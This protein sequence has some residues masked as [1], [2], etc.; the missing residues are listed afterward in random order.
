MLVRW[1]TVRSQPTPA[2]HRSGEE[3]AL[4]SV[5]AVALWRAAGEADAP[6][7][8]VPAEAVLAQLEPG[9]FWE[10]ALPTLQDPPWRQTR[11]RGERLLRRAQ[12][13]L[14]AHTV[15]AQRRER[16]LGETAGAGL[17]VSVG[18]RVADALQQLGSPGDD[19][20]AAVGALARAWNEG[21][22]H[23]SGWEL[24]LARQTRTTLGTRPVP[25]TPWLRRLTWLAGLGGVLGDVRSSIL[26]TALR[27]AAD[28]AAG[29][30]DEAVVAEACWAAWGA[31]QPLGDWERQHI[32]I[33]L[34]RRILA[35][36]ATL[37]ALD[38]V[39]SQLA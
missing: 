16:R 17:P 24:T 31:E 33:A 5:V 39:L 28:V 32:P 15:D 29:L 37:T 13:I 22:W 30:A 27:E 34:R 18:E 19:V 3:A 14:Q 20:P 9:E 35:A 2:A 7:D 4:A 11:A 25:G 6:V 10:G 21:R 8:V 12:R 1:W 26:N 36:E 23:P 38:A